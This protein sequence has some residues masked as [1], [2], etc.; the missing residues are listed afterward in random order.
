MRIVDNCTFE[1]DAALAIVSE[2]HEMEEGAGMSKRQTMEALQNLG[3][4]KPTDPMQ[5]LKR[6]GFLKRVLE[7]I[8]TLRFW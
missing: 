5:A 2:M 1:A 4:D 3:G 6:Q 8:E 7:I